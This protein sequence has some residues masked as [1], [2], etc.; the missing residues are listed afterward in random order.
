ME[1]NEETD[2]AAQ[3]AGGGSAT[4]T[5]SGGSATG[6]ACGGSAEKLEFQY[7]LLPQDVEVAQEERPP[8]W[9]FRSMGEKTSEQFAAF[10]QQVQTFKVED[11]WVRLSLEYRSGNHFVFDGNSAVVRVEELPYQTHWTLCTRYGG[12]G[13][14]YVEP[15]RKTALTMCV[16]LQEDSAVAVVRALSLAGTEK[17]RAVC[18]VGTARVRDMVKSLMEAANLIAAE[19]TRVKFVK[20]NSTEVVRFKMNMLLATW[21]EQEW[22]MQLGHK[23]RRR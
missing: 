9:K 7:A 2:A 3:T 5:S 12:F 14:L 11:Q 20:E 21:L 13:R 23:R 15:V 19:A 22:K 4:A 10:L 16:E 17:A 6:T 1:N 18:E 8:S